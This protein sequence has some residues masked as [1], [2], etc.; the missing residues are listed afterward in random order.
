MVVS[1]DERSAVGADGL[2]KQLANPDHAGVQGADIDGGGVEDSVLGIEE[3]DA[4][5]FLLQQAHL[6]HD[7]IG[8]IDGRADLRA[9]LGRRDEEPPAQFQGGLELR[10]LGWPKASLRRQLVGTGLDQATQAVEGLEQPLGHAQD[11][12]IRRPGAED[13]RQELA[14]R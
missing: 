14:R 5:V 11:V 4:Q 3:D 6:G 8:G 9:F 12:L 7:Q 10:N 13:D 2:A 1:D